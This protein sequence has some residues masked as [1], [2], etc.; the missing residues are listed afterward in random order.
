MSRCVALL[1]LMVALVVAA[2]CGG[3]GAGQSAKLGVFDGIAS[4]GDVSILVDGAT[5]SSSLQYRA[6]TVIC[7]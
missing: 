1:G 5:F 4:G 6:N 7:R 3:T 2:S